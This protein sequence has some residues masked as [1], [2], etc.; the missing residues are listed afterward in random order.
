VVGAPY[1]SFYNPS[2]SSSGPLTD[3]GAFLFN[4]SSGAVC[5]QTLELF[6]PDGYDDLYGVSTSGGGKFGASVAVSHAASGGLATVVVGACATGPGAAC[7]AADGTDRAQAQPE[8][9]QRRGLGRGV[10]VCLHARR[11]ELLAPHQ[12]RRAAADR[13]RYARPA[14][15]AS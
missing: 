5:A 15:R 10:R 1:A 8:R 4:C 14:R 7:G 2:V 13:R 9:L 12:D 3:G 11:R 6:A